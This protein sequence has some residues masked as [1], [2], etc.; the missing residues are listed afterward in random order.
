MLS[1]WKVKLQT[2][3]NCTSVYCVPMHI[4]SVPD[5]VCNRALCM[6]ALR[7]DTLFCQKHANIAVNV[8]VVHQTR[9]QTS[10]DGTTHANAQNHMHAKAFV[11]ALGLH[12]K[13]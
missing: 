12:V 4:F 3:E 1:V 5:I 13:R 8:Q 6:P 7:A 10:A 2:L 11:C 9:K